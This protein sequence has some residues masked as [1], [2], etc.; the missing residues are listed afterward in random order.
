MIAA[1]TTPL[2]VAVVLAIAAGVLRMDAPHLWE[3]WLL[4]SYAAATI[5]IGTL[6]LTAATLWYDHTGRTR[7][8]PQVQS[9]TTT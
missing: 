4:G 5:A 3:L 9:A 1:V 2:L 8:P 6:A 7:R